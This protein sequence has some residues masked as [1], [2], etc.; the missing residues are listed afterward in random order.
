MGVIEVDIYY[1]DDNNPPAQYE[2]PERKCGTI[3]WQRTV[4]RETLK[5][6]RSPKGTKYWILP[7]E[8]EMTFSGPVAQFRAFYEGKEVGKHEVAMNE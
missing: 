5:L 3:S 8:I 2:S 1:C 4:S 7:Y 6:A